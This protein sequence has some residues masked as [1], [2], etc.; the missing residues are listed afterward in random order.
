MNTLPLVTNNPA[1]LVVSLPCGCTRDLDCRHAAHMRV[2]P[3]L[4][5]Q[6]LAHRAPLY[7]RGIALAL[8]LAGRKGGT[9]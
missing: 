3:S 5:P 2:R 4:A 1:A 6:L 8:A 7:G 9:A